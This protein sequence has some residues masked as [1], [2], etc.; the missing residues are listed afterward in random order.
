MSYYNAVPVERMI[1]WV[2]M[3]IFSNILQGCGMVL[4]DVQYY[5]WSLAKFVCETPV[6]I[7]M[8]G[9]GVHIS[10]ALPVLWR[11]S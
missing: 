2:N 9:L 4:K 7:T 1:K 8:K 6:F 11:C 10:L 5:N 3:P